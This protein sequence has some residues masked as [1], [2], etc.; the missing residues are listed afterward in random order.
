MICQRCQGF[1]KA[2]ENSEAR[3]RVVSD[4]LDIAVCQA[5]A[6]DAKRLKMRVLEIPVDKPNQRA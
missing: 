6:E 4:L 1:E 2:P 3:Y 5:C